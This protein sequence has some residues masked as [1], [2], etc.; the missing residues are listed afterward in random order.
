MACGLME[1]SL[2]CHVFYNYLLIHPIGYCSLL[3]TLVTKLFKTREQIWSG[4]KLPASTA[5]KCPPTVPCTVLCRSLLRGALGI[6]K[7]N[8]LFPWQCLSEEK[9]STQIANLV[10][11]SSFCLEGTTTA[12]SRTFV[13]GFKNS[14]TVFGEV[15]ATDLAALY[16]GM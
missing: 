15:L 16:S 11:S 2:R 8:P 13:L 7:Q 1:Q 14:L 5:A 6:K 10:I 4:G 12:L 3:E 9:F